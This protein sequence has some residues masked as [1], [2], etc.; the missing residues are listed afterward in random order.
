MSIGLTFQRGASDCRQLFVAS[1]FCDDGGKGSIKLV[2]H[3]NGLDCFFPLGGIRG[4]FWFWGRGIEAFFFNFNFLESSN[5]MDS[6]SC[7]STVLEIMQAV[8]W[9]LPALKY[10]L[11]FC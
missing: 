9:G 4:G 2:H 11:C 8:V 7:K 10:N 5:S 6:F 3:R 1:A